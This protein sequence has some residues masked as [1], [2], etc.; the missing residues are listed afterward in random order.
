M[1]HV[2]GAPSRGQA[3]AG[4]RARPVRRG[5]RG[6]RLAGLAVRSRVTARPPRLRVR[7]LA[8]RGP[9]RPPRPLPGRRRRSA[10]AGD[11]DA[12]FS[13]AAFVRDLLG[14]IGDREPAALR[15]ALSGRAAARAPPVLRAWTRPRRPSATGTSIR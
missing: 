3:L 4:L 2:A 14:K 13:L 15:A 8:G 10:A 12:A 9:G 11:A 5:A 7:R 6:R 1:A